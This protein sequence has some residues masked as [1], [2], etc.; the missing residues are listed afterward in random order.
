MR[1]DQV[2]REFKKTL[3]GEE[4][5]NETFLVNDARS[6]GPFQDGQ[7]RCTNCNNEFDE[8]EMVLYNRK[9][10][11]LECFQSLYNFNKR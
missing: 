11:C 4:L 6:F 7:S 9:S 1:F 3:W 8:S 2:R 10:F 5:D